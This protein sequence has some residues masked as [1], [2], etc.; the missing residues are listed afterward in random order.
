M[1]QLWLFLPIIKYPWT[2]QQ[3]AVIKP[4]QGAFAAKLREEAQN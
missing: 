2:R 4:L 3:I 1:I